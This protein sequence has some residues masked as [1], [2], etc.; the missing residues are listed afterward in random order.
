MSILKEFLGNEPNEV[1]L[2]LSICLLE[3]VILSSFITE[4]VIALW[5]YYH[6]RLNSSFYSSDTKI[7][8]I[9]CIR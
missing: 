5:E 9:A 1:Q 3:N 4:P 7:Q 8:T 6:K 2:K